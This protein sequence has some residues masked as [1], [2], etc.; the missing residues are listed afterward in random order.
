[1][2]LQTGEM[3]EHRFSE[4]TNTPPNF[5]LHFFSCFRHW[6]TLASLVQDFADQV[7]VLGPL[8]GDGLPVIGFWDFDFN[9]IHGPRKFR[10]PCRA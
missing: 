5:T 2:I 10:H 6:D 3:N 9:G 1:M 8:K 7:L 4:L